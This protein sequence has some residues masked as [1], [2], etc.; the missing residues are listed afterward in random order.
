M[1]YFGQYGESLIEP[2]YISIPIHYYGILLIHFTFL[3]TE[4]D[5]IKF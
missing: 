3:Q 5:K 2:A 1:L 4:L